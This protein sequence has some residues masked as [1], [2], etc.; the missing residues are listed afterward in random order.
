[1]RLWNILEHYQ[2]NTVVVFLSAVFL[3]ITLNTCL[4]IVYFNSFCDLCYQLQKFKLDQSS[5]IAPKFSINTLSKSPFS[6]AF[7]FFINYTLFVHNIARL[8]R[9]HYTFHFIITQHSTALIIPVLF[10]T[11]FTYHC[12]NVFI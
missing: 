10:I 5:E 1:M 4:F 7:S 6:F 8:L 9:N 12:R 3:S 11:L 2:C